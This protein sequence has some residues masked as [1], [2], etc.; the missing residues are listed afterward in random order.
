V[1]TFDGWLKRTGSRRCDLTFVGIP[2]HAGHAALNGKSNASQLSNSTFQL[3]TPNSLFIR[4]VTF[5]SRHDPP[6]E[7]V[8]IHSSRNM[9]FMADIDL[10]CIQST[11]DGIVTFS[12]KE[13]GDMLM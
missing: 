12:V 11:T 13:P 9:L 6:G 8:N 7:C 4:H 10:S 2:K 3:T 1:L 5:K